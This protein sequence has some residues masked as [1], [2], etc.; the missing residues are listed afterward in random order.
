VLLTLVLN[1]RGGG[2]GERM[3]ESERFGSEQPR[4]NEERRNTLDDSV[5]AR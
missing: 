2:E 1:R 3:K 4:V 5:I